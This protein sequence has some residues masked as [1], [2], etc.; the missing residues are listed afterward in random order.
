MALVMERA[1]YNVM[2]VDIFP[3][4]VDQINKRTFNSAEPR[5]NEFL[6]ASKN[7]QATTDFKAACDWSDLLFILVDTPSTG[8]DRHYDC[9]KLGRVLND[10]NKFRLKNKHVII[11]CTVLPGY[12]AQTGRYLL[13][14]CEN[15]TL[16]YAP[17]MLARA[18]LSRPALP[19]SC[20]PTSSLVRQ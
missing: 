16:S 6:Q 4:Y 15:T 8:G 19:F 3:A 5:V 9:S 2:G 20:C 14:D 11:C 7:F 13:R 10:M 1:G 18:R 17:A 12:I